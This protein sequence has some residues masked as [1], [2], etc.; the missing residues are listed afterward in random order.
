MNRKLKTRNKKN[1]KK[2]LKERL[3]LMKR[4][5]FNKH[6]RKPVKKLKKN[7]IKKKLRVKLKTVPNR[8]K[9]RR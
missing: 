9:I 5:K 6:P 3:S 2:P 1:P 7:L 4:Q 8:L